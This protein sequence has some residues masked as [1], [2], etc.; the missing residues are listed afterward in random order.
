M[1]CL[2][3]SQTD[4]TSRLPLSPR[5]TPAEND[6]I[7]TEY[8]PNSKWATRIDAFEDFDKRKM[9]RPSVLNAKPWLPFHSQAEFVF[10]EIAL[11]AALSN[12]QLNALINIVNTVKEGKEE[13]QLRNHHDVQALWESASSSLT[14]VCKKAHRCI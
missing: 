11:H 7:R 1:N 8:H 4:D 9:P 12:K 6:D 3:P 14:P 10:A 13:F 5:D 2:H